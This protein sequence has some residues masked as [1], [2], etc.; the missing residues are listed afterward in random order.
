MGKSAAKLIDI[1]F[2]EHECTGCHAVM[3]HWSKGGCNLPHQILC[4]T[5]KNPPKE[6]ET[7][8]G[9]RA[10]EEVEVNEE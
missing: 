2:H 3:R 6:E 10:D 8:R 9:V 7:G 4:E 5:C 1:P